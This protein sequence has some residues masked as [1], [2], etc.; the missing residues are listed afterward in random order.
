MALAPG[1]AEA[2]L[3]DWPDHRPANRL[4]TDELARAGDHGLANYYR[5]RA[6]GPN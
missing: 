1:D 5:A 4:L 3:R 6:D 2:V